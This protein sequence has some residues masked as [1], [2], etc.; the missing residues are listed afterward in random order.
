MSYEADESSIRKF[1]AACGEINAVRLPTYPDSGKPRGIAFIEFAQS[2]GADKALELDGQ[3]MLGR[4]LKISISD[5]QPSAQKEKKPFSTTP[6]EKP[7]GCKTVFVGNLSWK[8][9]EDDLR[10]TFDGCGTILNARIAWDHENDRSKGFG[11]VDF[12]EDD[13]VDEAVKKTGQMCADRE[14]RVDFA[15]PRDNN[16]GG[17]RGGRGGGGRGGGGRGGG[18][19]G[20][21]GGGGRGGGRGGQ[22]APNKNKGTMITGQNKKM[23]FD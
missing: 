21:R 15:A 11:Y 17:G 1:F 22:G 18:F 8:A 13:A 6:G 10:A 7:A 2:T 14:V 3:E 23:T 9:T 19:G 4:W 16:G 12:E 5:G 20:G